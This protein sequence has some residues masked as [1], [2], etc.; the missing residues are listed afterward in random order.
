MSLLDARDVVKI[1]VIF[2]TSYGD[3]RAKTTS[4]LEKHVVEWKINRNKQYH[5]VMSRRW[6]HA[7]PQ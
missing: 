4:I 2:L 7:H 1:E 6:N 3:T 5:E